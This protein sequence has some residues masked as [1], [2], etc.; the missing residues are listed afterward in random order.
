MAAKPPAQ[1]VAPTL[2]MSGGGVLAG[3]MT[4]SGM[5][6]LRSWTSDASVSV[7]VTRITPSV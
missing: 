5:P 6:A 1:L 7:V 2:G 3:S 4:M